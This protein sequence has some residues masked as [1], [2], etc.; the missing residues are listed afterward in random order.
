MSLSCL[1]ILGNGE[2]ELCAVQSCTYRQ[3]E[4]LGLP[5]V[6][7]RKSAINKKLSSVTQ[8]SVRICLKID[9]F[10]IREEFQE[11]F[12]DTLMS[13]KIRKDSNTLVY[14]QLILDAYCDAHCLQ[15]IKD[16]TM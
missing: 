4:P 8:T 16:S 11:A 1:S 13:A 6:V 14:P 15:A 9:L 2:V 7:L 12:Y 5:V 10:K 3:T